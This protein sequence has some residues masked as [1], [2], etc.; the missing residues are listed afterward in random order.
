MITD[1]L[2]ATCVYAYMCISVGQFEAAPMCEYKQL[3]TAYEAAASS[4]AK[5]KL[6]SNK[7]N[8]GLWP[9][10]YLVVCV[11]ERERER[12]S[13]CRERKLCLY[14]CVCMLLCLLDAMVSGWYRERT[15]SHMQTAHTLTPRTYIHTPL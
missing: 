7:S 10:G 12:E 6:G 15:N 9:P 1:D 2:C 4:P 8:K 3:I 14:V 13:M 11:S 5:K